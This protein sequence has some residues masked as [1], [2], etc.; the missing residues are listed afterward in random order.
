MGKICPNISVEIPFQL[1]FHSISAISKPQ[2][3]FQRPL[4]SIV[5]IAINETRKAPKMPQ[6]WIENQLNNHTSVNENE[7]TSIINSERSKRPWAEMKSSKHIMF[8]YW[9]R[10]TEVSYALSALCSLRL[11]WAVLSQSAEVFEM[12]MYKY[13]FK[14]YFINFYTFLANLNSSFYSRSF[15]SW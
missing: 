11:S 2:N 14:A 12:L 8:R 15:Y 13:F 6:N 5:S 3:S 9:G 7:N 10:V 1:E 4:G